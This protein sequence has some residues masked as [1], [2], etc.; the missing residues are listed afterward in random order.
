MKLSV[1]KTELVTNSPTGVET[2]MTVTNQRLEVVTDDSHQPETG[3]SD[4]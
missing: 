1:E 4:R 3:G 2:Q